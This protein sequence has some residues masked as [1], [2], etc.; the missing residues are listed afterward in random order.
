MCL[1]AERCV[2]GRGRRW[3]RSPLGTRV[4][5]GAEICP[6]RFPALGT[7]S[8][9]GKLNLIDVSVAPFMKYEGADSHLRPSQPL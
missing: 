5:G 2:F 1:F 3:R 8:T 7:I 4:C 6:P 9:L